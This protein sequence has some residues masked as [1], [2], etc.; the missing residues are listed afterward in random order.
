MS[1]LCNLAEEQEILDL[2]DVEKL[3]GIPSKN[4]S[5]VYPMIWRLFPAL[6][7][8]VS[9]ISSIFCQIRGPS[10]Y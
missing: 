1:L 10:K 3:P 6:D 4:A 9:F 7:P 5:K 8:Q 2:C